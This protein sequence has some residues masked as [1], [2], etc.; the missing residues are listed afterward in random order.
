MTTIKIT[1][2]GIAGSGKTTVA[3]LIERALREKGFNVENG[4]DEQ[5]ADSLL[6]LRT[7]SILER[8]KIQI[9]TANVRRIF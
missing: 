3:T 6:E 7:A 8:T 9:D 5:V 4:D 2:A 1:I